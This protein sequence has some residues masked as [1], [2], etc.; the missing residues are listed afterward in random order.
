MRVVI[1]DL[2]GNSLFKKKHFFFFFLLFRG[3]PVEYVSSQARNQIRATAA[4]LH[5]SHN[6]VGSKL[7]CLQ[8]TTQLM[9][10]PD[11]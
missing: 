10:M 9:A 7:C 4:D 3:A 6:N 1:Y 5:H 11:P 8:P 2:V